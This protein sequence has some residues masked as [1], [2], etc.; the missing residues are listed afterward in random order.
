MT[1]F[2]FPEPIRQIIKEKLDESTSDESVRTLVEQVI[3]FE[4]I[5]LTEKYVKDRKGEYDKLIENAYRKRANVG[6]Q[7]ETT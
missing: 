6:E 4:C 1:I 5:H 2:V 3:E 7:N